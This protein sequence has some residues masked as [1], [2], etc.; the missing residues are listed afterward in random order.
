MIVPL[1]GVVTV[2]VYLGLVVE[3]NVA[4]IVLL[5]VITMVTGDVVDV[6]STCPSRETHSSVEAVAVTVTLVPESY[7][8]PVG[9]QHDRAI[10]GRGHGERVYLGRV[11]DPQV[12]SVEFA[13]WVRRA[14]VPPRA[15]RERFH[16]GDHTIVDARLE[17]ADIAPARIGDWWRFH[18]YRNRHR[19]SCL[20]HRKRTRPSPN[21]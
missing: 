12:L 8:P 20:C 18:P 16:E 7:E 6:E 17:V 1:V 2:S 3:V 19:Q 10:G 13:S 14:V 9:A 15:S 21:S 11:V 4:P 5:P